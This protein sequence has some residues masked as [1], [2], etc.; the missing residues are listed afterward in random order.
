MGEKAEQSKSKENLLNGFR[1][2]VE[3]L[4]KTK[5]KKIKRKSVSLE[6]KYKDI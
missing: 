4:L 3:L 6:A 5:F 2:P 1:N